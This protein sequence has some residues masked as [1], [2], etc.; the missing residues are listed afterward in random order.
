MS[1]SQLSSRKRAKALQ[2]FRHE[3]DLLAQ[4]KH[5]NLPNVSD[6]FE[7]GRKA[8][9]VMEFIEGKTLEEVL[10]EQQHPLDEGLVMDWASQLCAVLHYLHTRPQP[11]I[12]RERQV[13]THQPKN[14]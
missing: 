13:N 9:L 4:L 12:F 8:Y 11:I 2:D 6:M 14:T 5:P 1:D 10:E 7:E 3:A